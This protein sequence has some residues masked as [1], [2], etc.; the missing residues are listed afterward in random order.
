MGGACAAYV[1]T[2]AGCEVAGA[3]AAAAAVEAL[4]LSPGQFALSNQNPTSSRSSG[5]DDDL[6]RVLHEAAI[7]GDVRLL[8][9]AIA[10]G[11]D[12]NAVRRGSTALCSAC[13]NGHHQCVQRL[14]S[15]GAVTSLRAAVAATQVS[16]TPLHLAASHQSDSHTVCV[17]ALLQTGAD[18]WASFGADRSVA[19]HLAA[20]LASVDAVRLL[21]EMAQFRVSAFRQTHFH[22]AARLAAV[23]NSPLSA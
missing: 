23:Q 1:S 21:C 17:A 18:P 2:R 11:V 12:V 4:P 5:M 6:Q 13:L 14:L 10:K 3:A 20:G 15:A 7:S 8:E 22:A 19:L 9:S 16:L